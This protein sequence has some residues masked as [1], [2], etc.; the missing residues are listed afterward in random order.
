M[1]IPG[2]PLPLN[3]TDFFDFIYNYFKAEYAPIRSFWST[4]TAEPRQPHRWMAMGNELSPLSF[5]PANPRAQVDLES[6]DYCIRKWNLDATFVRGIVVRYCKY[7]VHERLEKKLYES[8]RVDLMVR[9][10]LKE[11]HLIDS[12]W[13]SPAPTNLPNELLQQGVQVRRWYGDMFFKYF[14]QLR[15]V[16]DF[17]LKPEVDQ[18]IKSSGT[19]ML[20]PFVDHLVFGTV[21]PIRPIMAKGAGFANANMRRHQREA[22]SFGEPDRFEIRFDA[23]GDIQDTHT[24]SV[25]RQCQ[26]LKCGTKRDVTVVVSIDPTPGSTTTPQNTQ[27]RP[28]NP[29]MSAPR[30]HNSK[31]AQRYTPGYNM[32]GTHDATPRQALPPQVEHHNASSNA[33]SPSPVQKKQCPRCTFL[34]HP[35]LAVCEMCQGELPDALVSKPTS[36]VQQKVAKPVHAHSASMPSNTRT[37]EL[38]KDERPATLN[39]HSLSSTLFSIFPFSQQHQTE[40]HVNLPVTQPT[41]AVPPP[42]E[43]S[44]QHAAEQPQPQPQPPQPKRTV[45]QEQSQNNVS[46]PPPTPPS[47]IE[48][49]RPSTPPQDEPSLSRHPEMTLMPLTPPPVSEATRRTTP[50]GLP[51]SL[52]DDFVPVSPPFVRDEDEDAG[53][54]EVGRH[55][56][57]R[58]EESDEESDEED[59]VERREGMVDLDAVAREEMGVWGE[60]EDD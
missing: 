32:P 18:K 25:V 42:S 30:R 60:R 5:R 39:R 19:L 33:R 37:E 20:V 38:Q 58:D 47:P 31:V 45:P 50:L 6:L 48:P 35:E 8:C 51:Q 26:C 41:I 55:E 56:A 59:V 2:G 15:A 16:D 22:G 28:S 14:R 10:A 9:K 49:A 34:N 13:P 4:A 27:R 17:A 7:E 57:R 3:E 44:T 43:A 46:P 29:N 23:P 40:H 54:G 36:P 53:W 24:R 52:M 21:E 1:A 12:L 11:K